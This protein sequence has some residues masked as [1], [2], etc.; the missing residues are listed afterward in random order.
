MIDN[1]QTLKNLD[2]QIDKLTQKQNMY[3]ILSAKTCDP[4]VIATTEPMYLEYIR[5]AMH[6]DKVHIRSLVFDKET[7]TLALL[8]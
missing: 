8:L 4:E 3:D 2:Q 6:Q 1:N 5:Q 7:R